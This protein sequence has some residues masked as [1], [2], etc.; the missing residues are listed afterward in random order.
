MINDF[1]TFCN[2]TVVVKTHDISVTKF[3]ITYGILIY[4]AAAKTGLKKSEMAQS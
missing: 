4:V 2:E 3:Q 1:Y